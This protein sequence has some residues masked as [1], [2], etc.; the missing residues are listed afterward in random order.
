[1]KRANLILFFSTF[2]QPQLGPMDKFKP[3]KQKEEK[4]KKEVS[5]I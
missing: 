4:K 1:M 3:E 2:L 5:V